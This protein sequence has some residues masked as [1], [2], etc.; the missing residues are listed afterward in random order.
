MKMCMYVC[1]YVI[2][3]C[4]L[5]VDNVELPDFFKIIIIII[6]GISYLLFSYFCSAFHY[7]P[8]WTK[9]IYIVSV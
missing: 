1:V 3:I 7:S 5:E 6:I 8:K 2:F 9:I 4:F